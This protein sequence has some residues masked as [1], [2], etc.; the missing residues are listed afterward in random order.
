MRRSSVLALAATA[1]V[2]TIPAVAQAASPSLSVTPSHVAFGKPVTISGKHW[3]VIEFCRPTLRI[4]LVG[5]QNM[6]P[7]G[8]VHLKDDGTFKKTWTPRKN[9]VGAGSWKIRVT[10]HCESGEDGSTKLVRRSAPLHIG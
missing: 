6:L 7:V 10:Q 9:Q 8:T 1:A 3:A 4:Q 5:P 2:A